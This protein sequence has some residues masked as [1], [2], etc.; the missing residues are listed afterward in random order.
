MHDQTTQGDTYVHNEIILLYTYIHGCRICR[1]Q[2]GDQ[3]KQELH[4]IFLGH[5]LVFD[6]NLVL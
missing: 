3:C 2:A 1:M 5:F 4:Q 6:E